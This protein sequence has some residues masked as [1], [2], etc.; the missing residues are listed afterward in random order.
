MGQA[1]GNPAAIAQREDPAYAT[2]T[3]TAFGARATPFIGGALTDWFIFG[4]GG[5]FSILDRKGLSAPAYL[6][7]FHL[8]AFPLFRL[9]GA[10]QDAGLFADFGAGSAYVY[11]SD[12]SKRASAAIAS[13]LGFGAFWEGLRWGHLAAGPYAGYQRNWGDHFSRDDVTLGL[14]LAVY[15]GP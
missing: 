2:R 14:R 9:G 5:S 1:N 4:L 3:G 11:A 10:W 8:E 6:A 13:A 7:V 12:G 15:G